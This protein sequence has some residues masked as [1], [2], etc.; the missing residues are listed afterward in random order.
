MDATAEFVVIHPPD[1]KSAPVATDKG[2]AVANLEEWRDRKMEDCD[3][4]P[5]VNLV[6]VRSYVITCRY[7]V[8]N[9]VREIWATIFAAKNFKISRDQPSSF[10]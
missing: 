5:R 10:G 3:D 4:T 1:V 9:V 2:D 8:L 6:N 7:L